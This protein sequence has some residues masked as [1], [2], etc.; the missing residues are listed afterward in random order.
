MVRPEG[1]K[2]RLTVHDLSI[3]LADFLQPTVTLADDGPL[4]YGRLEFARLC[5]FTMSICHIATA[6]GRAS[7][8]RRRLGQRFVFQ[9]PRLRQPRSERL[10]LGLQVLKGPQLHGEHPL[11]AV[12]LALGLED[13]RRRLVLEPADKS[14]RR[15]GVAVLLLLGKG[16]H[17]SEL[18]AAGM[19]S[20]AI[21]HRHVAL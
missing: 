7:E 16:G 6:K 21:G 1:E 13:G 18:H 2:R 15:R 4:I 3:M 12:G 5:I 17:H 11:Q 10:V 19:E 14:P 20:D 9:P 8:Q